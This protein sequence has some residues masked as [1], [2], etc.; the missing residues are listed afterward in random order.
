MVKSKL[1]EI[2]QHYS[3]TYSMGGATI[4]DV[5]NELMDNNVE[6]RG[7]SFF[8]PIYND[9]L[10]AVFLLAGTKD[11][12]DLWVLKKIIKVLRSGERVFTVL[13]GNSDYIL[14]QLEK[15]NSKIIKRDGD[16]IYI[17]FN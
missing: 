11:R 9:E 2:L 4:D 1:K 6:V 10:S 12:A 13:N 5:Y 3:D 14:P 8:C 16:V 17:Q 15:F 7:D